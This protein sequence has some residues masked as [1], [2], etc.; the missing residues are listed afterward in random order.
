MP[1]DATVTL[2]T[3][4]R[5][6]LRLWRVR[7]WA[8]ATAIAL[9]APPAAGA[10]A[11]A[12]PS[13]DTC[14]K[15]LS[16]YQDLNNQSSPPF[17][18]MKQTDPLFPAG[19][20]SIAEAE[21]TCGDTAHGPQ[22]DCT[23][24]NSWD[25][26]D[27]IAAQRQKSVVVFRS[28]GGNYGVNYDDVDQGELGDCYLLAA[29]AGI[30][31][32]KPQFIDDMFTDRN[33]WAS[34]VYTTKWMLNGK[35][36]KV[37]VN[38]KVPFSATHRSSFFA[39]PNVVG[40]TMVFWP[41]IA[42]KAW[43]KIYHN[44]EAIEGGLFGQVI[45]A[46]TAAN[47]KT[48]IHSTASA[49]VIWSMLLGATANKFPMG[50]G[51][52]AHASK[53]KM[54]TGHAYAVFRARLEGG[55]KLV[56]CMNPWGRDVYAGAV[57]NP[58]RNDG[59]FTMLMEEYFDAFDLTQIAEV[60]D[61]YKTVSNVVSGSQGLMTGLKEFDIKGSAPFSVAVFWP[62]QH[63][64]A[65][66]SVPDPAVV[67]SVAKKGAL[68]NSKVSVETGLTA[69]V[70][71]AQV[72][73]DLGPGTYVM[74]VGAKF[75]SDPW[76]PNVFMTVYAPEVVTITNS[77]IDLK[78]AIRSMIEP[79]NGAALSVTGIDIYCNGLFEESPSESVLG[80]PVYLAK[81]K[82]TYAFW[83]GF[84]GGWAFI[85]SNQ[86]N[87]VLTGANFDV[88]VVDRSRLGVCGVQDSPVL[89]GYQVSCSVVQQRRYSNLGCDVPAVQRYCPKTC[90]DM[91]AQVT[92]ISQNPQQVMPSCTELTLNGMGRYN[93][94]LYTRTSELLNGVPKY[95]ASD[96]RTVLYYQ[97]LGT[98][99][100]W[101]V[102]G[103]P[104][105]DQIKAGTSFNNPCYTK[106]QLQASCGRR[107]TDLIGPLG[108]TCSVVSARKYSNVACKGQTN[109]DIVQRYCPGTC[110]R[111][112]RLYD[113]TRSAPA[114]AP[115]LERGSAV[116]LLLSVAAGA[117]LLCVALAR[118]RLH[119]AA[120]G[121]GDRM[122]AALVQDSDTEVHA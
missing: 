66:C 23:R 60:K 26:F 24:F 79:C 84:L 110:A 98:C 115:L 100:G 44:F 47:V 109:S 111:M 54:P 113:A 48:V 59:V 91:Q 81:D 52:N 51:T 41:L 71:M 3:R 92:A 75:Q 120:L 104:Q 5:T 103:T 43:A 88:A 80:I 31:Y 21:Q 34:G 53:Y 83:D 95:L 68:G 118:R 116:A 62:A 15:K 96:G 6:L 1:C 4:P 72:D 105:W 64:V 2:Y 45:N 58:N 74:Y 63:M 27:N 70:N 11:A 20:Q 89:G 112:T 122:L 57:P 87:D 67:I 35:E 25:T 61:G 14:A 9:A 22:G 28:T 12:P 56:E 114:P 29:L 19:M 73:V 107:D 93:D 18:F 101:K 50:A 16:W 117:A 78:T 37:A 85:G 121:P 49:D 39:Q 69:G 13:D 38:N 36:V 99:S 8:A 108:V 90:A 55:K 94:G 10:A 77:G 7:G 102:I 17:P 106:D 82:K 30:A 65:P 33:F 42:E 32:A 46:L 40:D 119:A 76:I 86:W 97:T